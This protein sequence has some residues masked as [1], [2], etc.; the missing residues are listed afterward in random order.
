MTLHGTRA[1][2]T[3]AAT[4]IGAAIAVA[5]AR[6]GADVAFLDLADGSETEA[7]IRARGPRG[8]RGSRRRG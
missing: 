2:V 4:G 5:L 7:A 3:G 1:V 6:A 8:A